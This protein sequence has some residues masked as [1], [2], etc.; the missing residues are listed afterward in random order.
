MQFKEN[1]NPALCSSRSGG[2]KE[3]SSSNEPESEP[4]IAFDEYGGGKLRESWLKLQTHM[5]KCDDTQYCRIFDDLKRARKHLQ[6]SSHNFTQLS[7]FHGFVADFY[8]MIK[9]PPE[10]AR[11]LR[12]SSTRATTNSV[13]A[14]EWRIKSLV[15]SLGLTTS[16]KE[17]QA[18]RLQQRK[19][20]IEFFVSGASDIFLLLKDLKSPEERSVLL[21][22]LRAEIENPPETYTSKE[23]ELVKTAYEEIASKLE[24]DDLLELIPECSLAS[25]EDNPLISGAW[26][27]IAPECVQ[28]DSQRPTFASDVY[29]LGMRIVEAL[30]VVEAVKSGKDSRS[31]LPWRLADR[32]AVRY[33]ATRGTLPSRPKRCEDRVWELVTR[34]CVLESKNRIKISTV[35]DEL[36]RLAS[37]HYTSEASQ[38]V[39]TLLSNSLV[40]ESAP[41][42]IAAGLQLL[43]GLQNDAR[44]PEAVLSLYISLRNRIRQVYKRINEKQDELCR[45]PFCL[46]LIATNEATLDLRDTDDSLISVAVMTMRCY[47]LDRA[48]AKFCEAHFLVYLA[49]YAR[50][51]NWVRTLFVLLATPLPCLLVTLTIDVMPLS[52]PYSGIATNKLF[53]VREYYAYL[54]M[55]S[56]ALTSF[57]QVCR[58]SHIRLGGSSG[59]HFVVAALTV[60]IIYGLTNAIGF[61]LPFTAIHYLNGN[62]AVGYFNFDSDGNSVGKDDLADTKRGMVYT[63]LLPVIKLFMRNLFVRAVGRVGDETPE[64]VVFNADVFGSLFI[65]YCMQSSPF[66]WT[67]LEIMVADVVLM[68]LT[69]RDIERARAGLRALERQVDD[70]RVWKSCHG[71]AIQINLSSCLPTSLD[72]ASILLEM[73]TSLEATKASGV[74]VVGRT[75][76]DS[77]NLTSLEGEEDAGPAVVTTKEAWSP[78][79]RWNSTSLAAHFLLKLKERMNRIRIHPKIDIQQVLQVVPTGKRSPLSSIELYTRKVR[80]LLLMAEFLLLINYVEVIIPLVFSIYLFATYHLPNREYYAVYNGMDQLRLANTLKNVLFYCLLQLVSLLVLIVILQRMLGHSPAKRIAFVLEKQVDF[81]QI[82]LVFW[83][84]YNVQT[85]LKHFGYDYTFQFAWLSSQSEAT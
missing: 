15:T 31:C 50:N 81:E 77:P 38:V 40:W 57:V 67:T 32:A 69:L 62:G 52:S 13:Y 60:G 48:L 84:F 74:S 21:K 41:Q 56:L 45:A 51:T 53:F 39:D 80:R 14:F 28:D 61:P 79:K 5:E 29:S 49:K 34:M 35:V 36:M 2:V 33:H 44:Q 30:R 71:A 63:V 11:I 3:R 8:R 24:R 4:L 19:E 78:Q 25:I 72:R 47:A 59:T 18:Q 58:Y 12:L 82:S 37:H 1:P 46:L 76:N 66:F 17:T 9:M 75:Q 70:N 22:R 68:G 43:I 73:E 7:Q 27:W 16:E 10:Q 65:S 42:V 64:L 23:L 54:A 6:A 55:T 26:Q 83:M 20:Q 85:S